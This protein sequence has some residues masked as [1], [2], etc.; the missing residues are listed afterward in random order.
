[1]KN[2]YEVNGTYGSHKTPCT[3]FYYDGWYVCDGSV[4]I[5]YTNEEITEGCD[6]ESISDSDIMTA[7]KPIESL[8]ELINEIDEM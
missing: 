2:Q 8:E 3:I 4:N 1:M 5:N 6:V 7:N